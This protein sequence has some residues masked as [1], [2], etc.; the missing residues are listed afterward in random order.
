MVFDS[1]LPWEEAYKLPVED[2]L[3]VI[4]GDRVWVPV[5]VTKVGA[6]FAAAWRAGAEEASRVAA[7]EFRERAVDTAVAWEE[8]TAV[9]PPFAGDASPP[10][11]EVMLEEVAQQRAAVEELID[12]HIER[13]YLDPLKVNPDNSSLWLELTRTYVRLGRYEVAIKSATSRLLDLG[14]Q[15]AG[16]LDQLGN[17]YYLKGELEQAALFY[18]QAADLAPEDADILRNLGRALAALGKSDG[19]KVRPLVDTPSHESLKKGE[20]E[21]DENSFYWKE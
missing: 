21:M 18:R 12:R 19:G 14:G 13:R 7:P 16:L 4:R 8:Y 6:G 9:S 20:V 10:G 1:G 15:D 3:Y 5:E 2:Q 11:R 17:V